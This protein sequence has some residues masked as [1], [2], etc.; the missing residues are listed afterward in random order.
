MTRIPLLTSWRSS[1]IAYNLSC[2]VCCL[3]IH[4][5]WLTQGRGSSVGIVTHYRLDD[6]GI[7]F[8]WGGGEIFRTCPYQPWGPP[9]LLYNGYR[10]LPGVKRPRRGGDHPPHVA[11][12][13]KKEWSYTSTSLLGRCGLFYGELWTVPLLQI[14]I[15]LK[16]LSFFHYQLF[17]LHP[18][19][20][21]IHCT[22]SGIAGN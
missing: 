2:F 12:R 15:F 5:R 19:N 1:F 14:N 13:L 7:E 11:P 21:R 22:Q 10:V 8:R 20:C 3:S 18:A 17:F 9:S 16:V 4:G 6:S